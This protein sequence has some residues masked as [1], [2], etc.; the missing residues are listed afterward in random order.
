MAV[1]KALPR[2]R[3]ASGNEGAERD[4]YQDLQ[5]EHAAAAGVVS[6]VQFVVEGAVEPGNP[7]QGEHRGELAQSAPGEV[8]GQVMGDQ[9]DD[10]EIVEQ[11]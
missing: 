8:S 9:D 1:A 3:P 6:A 5:Q 10:N 7:H 11:F 2:A 4:E